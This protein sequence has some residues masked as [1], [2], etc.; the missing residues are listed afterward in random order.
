M[1]GRAVSPDRF[2]DVVGAAIDE[3]AAAHPGKTVRA[4]G[5]MVD[6]LWHRGQE[7][8]ALVLEE[9]WNDL[10]GTKPFSLLCGYCL[11]LFDADVQGRALPEIFCRHSHFRAAAAPGRLAAAV[12]DALAEIL[13]TL[14]AARIY[15]DFAE[16]VPPNGVPRAQALLMWLSARDKPLAERVL[17]RVRA[18]YASPPR[19]ALRVAAS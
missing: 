9:L 7:Q 18:R 19:A 16:Q 8:A 6:V 11:D 12:H 1:D 17:D 2:A 3:A 5:E 10:G 15:L 14:D 13:G 4:F